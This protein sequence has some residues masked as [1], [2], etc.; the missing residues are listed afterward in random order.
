MKRYN[1]LLIIAGLASV[2]LVSGCSYQPARIK[3]EP[4]FEIDDGHG[5]RHHD[6]R[7]YDGHY[8]DR[9]DRRGSFCPPGQAKKG[10]C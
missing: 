7:H 5:H 9:R 10:R 6:K 3:S 8:D 2:M 1:A 4:L